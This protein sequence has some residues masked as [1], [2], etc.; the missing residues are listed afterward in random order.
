M[1]QQLCIRQNTAYKDRI[2]NIRPSI[3]ELRCSCYCCDEAIYLN[4]YFLTISN[5]CYHPSQGSCIGP[6]LFIL[7]IN[8]VVGVIG[9]DCQCKLYADDLKISSE[10]KTQ[11]DDDLLQGS[12][13]ALTR[14]S[15][16]WQLTISTKKYAILNIHHKHTVPSRDYSL[17]ECIIS[18]HNAVKDLGV[19]V[20]SDV[21]CTLHINNFAARAHSRDNLIHKC[22]V[23]KD[24]D[25]LLRACITYVRPLLVYASQAWSPDLVTDI[26]KLEAVQRRFTKRLKG[27]ENMDYPSRLK[28]LA[29]DSLQKR[30]VL[31]DLIFTYEVLFG[32]ND[33][34][35]SEFF[36]LNNNY[37][38]TYKLHFSYFRVDTRKYFFSKRIE[39][40]WNSLKACDS[41]FSS[42]YSFKLLLRR[43]DISKFLFFN[44]FKFVF[45]LVS[46]LSVLL[47]LGNLS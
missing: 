37:K 21:K 32:L 39:T 42:L 24:R 16:D 36:T 41:D 5:L 14:W 7:Y 25:S 12:R 2:S 45:I 27:M 28:A 9:K 38:E 30:R 44:N 43:S 18:T 8:D 3:F 1:D 11:Q 6:L 22:F 23:S 46:C 4:S 13:D 15:R 47:C 35:S 17:A 31:A 20:D 40:M 19:T 34:N 33:M 29:I 10:I 26:N